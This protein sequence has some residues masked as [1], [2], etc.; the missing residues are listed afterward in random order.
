MSPTLSISAKLAPEMP[1]YCHAES[2]ASNKA[3]SPSPEQSTVCRKIQSNGGYASY[4]SSAAEEAT[5]RLLS[6]TPLGLRRGRER[7]GLFPRCSERR[8]V[9]GILH[10]LM[11]TPPG[12]SF[13]LN[14]RVDRALASSPLPRHSGSLRGPVVGRARRRE[15]QGSPLSGIPGGA[16]NVDPRRSLGWQR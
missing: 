2:M 13:P 11:S 14:D 8:V 5:R 15:G 12:G 10:F 6:R 9:P 4:R 1:M 7:G 16:E 3:P